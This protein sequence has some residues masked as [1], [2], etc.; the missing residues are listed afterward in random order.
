[1]QSE[2]DEELKEALLDSNTIIVPDGIGIIKGAT[3]LNYNIK[4]TILGGRYCYKII[5]I[6]RPI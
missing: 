2:K 3:K 4:E 5:R 1:M 6:C